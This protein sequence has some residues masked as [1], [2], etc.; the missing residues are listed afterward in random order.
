MR[1]VRA[2]VAAASTRA[3]L[4]E[5]ACAWARLGHARA[6][7][8]CART[9]CACV[10]VRASSRACAK[11]ASL[12]C[13]GCCTAVCSRGCMQYVAVVACNMSQWLHA[14]DRHMCARLSAAIA[15]IIARAHTLI[16]YGCAMVLIPVRFLPSAYSWPA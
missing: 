16:A 10:W 3:C 1:V 7:V 13:A 8:R 5:P 6:R 4:L 15:R 2:S 9:M 14:I 11:I 12:A